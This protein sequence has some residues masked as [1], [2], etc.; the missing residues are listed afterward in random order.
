[1]NLSFYWSVGG[2]W[3]R[4]SRFAQPRVRGEVFVNN[5]DG[6]LSFRLARRAS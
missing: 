2:S 3:L 4:V 6:H 1:M 5:S